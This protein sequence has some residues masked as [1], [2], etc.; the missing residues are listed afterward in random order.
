MKIADWTFFAIAKVKRER[1]EQGITCTVSLKFQE[2][3]HGKA[4][5]ALGALERHSRLSVFW[6]QCLRFLGWGEDLPSS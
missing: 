3:M 2:N 4:S 6:L 1:I 5:Q